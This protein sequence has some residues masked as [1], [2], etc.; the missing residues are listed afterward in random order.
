MSKKCPECGEI[1]PDDINFC[2]ECGPVE[3][4]SVSSHQSSVSTPVSSH[5]SSVSTP[6]SSQQSSVS[7]PVSSQQSPVSSETPPITNN[8]LPIT[9]SD[10]EHFCIDWNQSTSVFRAGMSSSLQFKITPLNKS[11]KTATEVI[12]YLRYPGN[13]SYTKENLNFDTI[14]S[15]KTITIN[16][17]PQLNTIGADLGVD[18]YL[19]YKLNDKVFWFTDQLLIDI[20]P[21]GESNQSILENVSIKIENLTQNADKASDNKLSLLDGLQ[22]KSAKTA[23]EYLDA[24][25]KSDSAWL[26]LELSS[27]IPLTNDYGNKKMSISNPKESQKRITLKTT[28]GIVYV[29]TNE[30]ILGR[31]KKSEIITRNIPIAGESP[32]D[33]DTKKERNIRISSTHC[34]IGVTESEVWIKDL[35]TNGTYINSRKLEKD[36]RIIEPHQNYLLELAKEKNNRWNFKLDIRVYN[37]LANQ[38]WMEN[39]SSENITGGIVLKRKDKIKESYVVLNSCIAL[40]TII[41]D[42]QNDWFLC[43]KKSAFAITNGTE[44]IWLD[45]NSELPLKII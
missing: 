45:D 16:Y 17:S 2:E 23:D 5:Q 39:N 18:F 40:S 12:L 44:W 4:E 32:W 27:A 19:V 36:A 34:K 21:P 11:A 1:Y 43:R 35:S 10:C 22:N 42:A 13:N 33:N 8:Q 24:L 30:V 6:V 20:Y 41:D 7:T 14:K 28:S 31:S 29:Y 38:T 3:W 9:N 25:K 15:S 37:I 26:E